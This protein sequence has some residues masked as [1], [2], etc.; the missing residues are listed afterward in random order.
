MTVP[1]AGRWEKVQELFTAALEVAPAERRAFVA[2]HCNSD[3]ELAMEVLSLLASDAED[4]G[5][6]DALAADLG[7]LVCEPGSEIADALVGTRLDRYTIER[8]VARGGMGTVYLARRSD[9]TYD[10]QVALK[11]IRRGMDSEQI[12]ARFLVERQILARLR[13]PNIANLLDGGITPDGRPYLVMEYVEGR[14]IDEYCRDEGLGLTARVEL[15][16]TVCATVQHAHNNLVVHR[17]LKPSNILV[18]ADGTVKLMDF[19][20]AKLLEDDGV[21]GDAPRTIPGLQV[22][23]PGYAAPEQING[24]PI[25]TA[26]DVFGLGLVLYQVLTGT[27]P[28]GGSEATAREIATETCERDPDPPSRKVAGGEIAARR[29]AGD[30]DNIVLMAL[31]REPE[32]RYNSPGRLADDLGRHLAAEPVFARPATLQ[33]RTGKLISR[34]RLAFTAVAAVLV[35]TVGLVSFYTAQLAHERD[36]ARQGEAKA[37]QVA[38][39]LTDMF[40]LADPDQSRGADI[41]AREILTRGAENVDTGLA[42][43][44]A[45]QG[46]MLDVLGGVHRGLGMYD[47]SRDL[48]TRSLDIKRSLHGD[49]HL[50]VASTA[51]A[52]GLLEVESGNYAVAESLLT[53]AL[54]V[55]RAELGS[56]D[57][58]VASDLQSLALL[59]AYQDR[60]EESLVYYREASDIYE[61]DP[62][63]QD[64]DYG[65]CLNDYAMMLLDWGKG[66][67]AE[68]MFRKALDIQRR[69]LGED[70]PE[71]A[72]T[73]FNLALLL[74]DRGDYKAAAPIQRQVLA[75]DRQH[76]D[77]NHPNV[78]HSLMAL[79]STLSENGQ[80]DEAERVFA[81]ALEIRRATLAPGHPDLIK[82]LGTVGLTRSRAGHYAE[83]EPLLREAVALSREH[84]GAHRITAGRLDDLGWLLH[85]LG[86]D[87]E[88]LVLHRE[89]MGIKLEL[90]GPGHKVVGITN[91]HMARAYQGL[92]DLEAALEAQQ[93][94]VEI[95]RAEF[96]VENR[97][98]S[99]AELGLAQVFLKMGRVDEAFVTASSAL[100]NIRKVAEAD[101]PRTA[102]GLQVVGVIQKERGNL[103]DAE[104]LMRQAVGIRR[105]RLGA[106]NPLTAWSEVQLGELLLENGRREEAFKLAKGGLG[107][108]ERRLPAGHTRVLGAQ[109]IVGKFGR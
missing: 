8:E 21:V 95:G 59:A 101:S 89:A 61:S 73:L 97:F 45:V 109:E 4:P 53:A 105:D 94:A 43:Q 37:E 107:V 91:M 38:A 57:P 71:V 60:Y 28:F 103:M 69:E 20:I 85:D 36:L 18:T 80:Y 90:V 48:L 58:L 96:G 29:L 14:P 62:A 64:A 31:R 26:T 5:Y 75:L 9:G 70:H 3:A 40:A 92:G 39:F 76:Y 87:E 108:L 68:P 7:G 72:N 15:M 82:N 54:E 106:E 46:E 99:T 44:P 56:L 33:Y 17:D 10:E 35:V 77:D 41:T 100:E 79:G 27:R 25:T 1:D 30:L 55:H 34:Y 88:A 2:A 84:L 6:L 13:H 98:T 78:A 49:R 102:S 81:E 86:R 11:V 22:L 65:I 67:Q 16:R 104:R 51:S 74:K 12:T 23:T 50:E 42:D 19:G 24:D 83:A 93:A 52:L 63:L 47:E 66:D 32:R